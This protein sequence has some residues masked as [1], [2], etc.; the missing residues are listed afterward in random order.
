MKRL[1]SPVWLRRIWCAIMAANFLLLV[2][3]TLNWN[4]ILRDGSARFCAEIFNG[5]IEALWQETEELEVLCDSSE[6]T[7]LSACHRRIES[8][9]DQLSANV[10]F[11]DNANS[12]MRWYN[13]PGR[14]IYF[15]EKLK[16]KFWH[17]WIQEKLE[18][19]DREHHRQGFCP[20]DKL[21][22]ASF[23][24][25]A[26]AR[27]AIS[28]PANSSIH[29]RIEELAGIMFYYLPYDDILPPV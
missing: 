27:G 15:Q 19:V 1:I 4:N 23:G 8:L 18:R 5:Q 6:P 14:A 20:L 29:R 11:V 9:S 17:V 25:R 3:I 12:G 7:L 24:A 10:S 21:L 2:G 28:F 26:P 13:F 22:L 16:A